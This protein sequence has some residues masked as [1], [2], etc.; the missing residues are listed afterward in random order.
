[1]GFGNPY[2]DEWSPDIAAEWTRRL[3]EDVGVEVVSLADTIGVADPSTIEYLFSN[4]I[5]EFPDLE[6]G[7]HFHTRPDNWK[8]KVE[9]AY[10]NGCLRFDGA[11]KGFGGC[12]MAEDD[13]VGNMATENLIQFMGEKDIENSLD[14]EAFKDAAQEALKTFP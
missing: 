13:L 2:G 8:E 3:A 14:K 11:M 12:P 4:L 9:A 1:M 6:I 10:K 7:A 5:P